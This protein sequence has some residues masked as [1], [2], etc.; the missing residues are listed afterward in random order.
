M[1]RLVIISVHWA[2][3]KISQIVHARIAPADADSAMVQDCPHALRVRTQQTTPTTKSIPEIGAQQTAAIYT[4]GTLSTTHVNPAISAA[5]PVKMTPYPAPPATMFPASSTS[6]TTPHALSPVP[7]GTTARAA[8]TP[9]IFVPTSARPAMG[10]MLTSVLSAK[11]MILMCPS[12]R[13][14]E[15]TSVWLLAIQGLSPT[16]VLIPAKY[17]THNV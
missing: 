10:P 13:N 9:A 15:Q 16:L 12:T 14:G 2:H 5:R 3:T 1:T 11:P 8:T 6:T 7:R 4:M 17:V